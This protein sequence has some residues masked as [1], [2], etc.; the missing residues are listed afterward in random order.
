MHGKVLFWAQMRMLDISPARQLRSLLGLVVSSQA[1][2]ASLS[3]LNV[4]G[5]DLSSVS[6]RLLSRAT[7]RLARATF[8]DTNLGPDQ[9]SALFT[10]ILETED[11]RLERLR[12]TLTSL[13]TVQPAT[14][15]RAVVRLAEIPLGSSANL[16][17]DQKVAVFSEIALSPVLRLRKLRL[18]W[19]DLSS[20]NPGLFSRALVR[21]EQVD[22]YGS[23]HTEDQ[24]MELF[25]LIAA[26]KELRLR[27]L[28][29][30]SGVTSN[31]ALTLIPPAVLS[32]ALVRLEKVDLS[33]FILTP[34]QGKTLFKARYI[35]HSH[36]S[37]ASQC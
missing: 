21:L 9:V 4:S 14:L 22:L 37:R 15:A 28:R 17:E 30:L 26:T 11:L 35:Q 31:P 33:S 2:Q 16:T 23:L 19:L 29:L 13:E 8:Y 12:I 1:S 18:H 3:S 10:E 36:W 5:S 6:P 34:L 7:V 20:V 32:Q 24:V 27:N 25:Q